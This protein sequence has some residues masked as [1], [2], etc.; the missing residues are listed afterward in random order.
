MRPVFIFFGFFLLFASGCERTPSATP[1][2]LRTEGNLSV[3]GRNRYYLLNLPPNY[4]ESTDF[5]LV[6]ALHGGGGKASQM[7]SD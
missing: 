6:I 2:L 7:E 5:S 4:D 3:D 1:T